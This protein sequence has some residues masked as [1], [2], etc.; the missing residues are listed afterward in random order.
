M[1]APVPPLVTPVPAHPWYIDALERVA[2]TFVETFTATLLLA[3]MLDMSTIKAAG[4]AGVASA[5]AVI[6]AVAARHV[7]EGGTAATLP[8]PIPELPEAA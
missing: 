6:K 1:N 4:L 3:G 2:W 8:T 7:G 5:L